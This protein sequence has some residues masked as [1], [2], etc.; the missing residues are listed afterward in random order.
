MNKHLFLSFLF[1]ISLIGK[2]GNLEKGENVPFEERIQIHIAEIDSL[3][4]MNPINWGQVNSV[5]LTLSSLY[6]NIGEYS[7]AMDAALTG[8]EIAE[9]Y[10]NNEGIEASYQDVANSLRYKGNFEEAHYYMRK[11]INGTKKFTNE[12]KRE[13]YLAYFYYQ[14]T[15]IFQEEGVHLDSALYFHQLSLKLKEKQNNKKDIP[16]SHMSIGYIHYLMGSY[17]KATTS[18]NFSDSLYNNIKSTTLPNAWLRKK[19]KIQNYLGLVHFASGRISEAIANFKECA[20]GSNYISVKSILL[21]SYKNLG[22]C[23]ELENQLDS[24]LLYRNKYIALNNSIFNQKNAQQLEELKTVYETEKKN[25]TIKIQNEEIVENRNRINRFIAIVVALLLSIIA[26]FIFFKYKRLKREKELQSK[27][28]Q[29]LINK[30]EHERERIS[31]DLHDSVGQNLLIIKNQNSLLKLRLKDKQLIEK[32]E[33]INNFAAQT[34]DEL[35]EISNNLTPYQLG[36]LGLTK[37]IEDLID[38]VT[39]SSKISCV[40]NISNIDNLV[41]PSL[42]INLYRIVQESLNNIIKHSKATEISFIVSTSK[43]VIADNG[44]GFN[45]TKTSAGMGIGNLSER[46]KLLKADSKIESGPNLGTKITLQFT[47]QK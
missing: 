9:T 31:R 30:V 46:A 42:Q 34:I 14:Y 24:A 3:K 40:K 2:S 35:R 18:L 15:L 20:Y 43:I 33:T 28:S 22:D 21:S 29:D 19:L 39:K 10:R 27:F 25:E 36:R 37:A 1:F 45:T 6:R 47:S 44:V 12:K 4:A 41:E 32:S 38:K 8:V 7:K 23:Y 11:A 13:I 26:L 5:Y 16:K 17:E